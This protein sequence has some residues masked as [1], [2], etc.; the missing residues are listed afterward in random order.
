[1]T[2]YIA[3]NLAMAMQYSN[4][5]GMSPSNVYSSGQLALANGGLASLPRHRYQDGSIGGGTIQGTPMSG[6]RTGYFKPWKSIKKAAKKIAKPFVKT[7]KKIVPKELAGIMQVAAPFIAPS[8]PWLA[9]GLSAAGQ[10]RQRGRIS[11]LQTLLSTAPGWT[12]EGVM[13]FANRIPG[14]GRFADWVGKSDL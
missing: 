10:A 13:K 9:A 1:M 4:Q 12:N 3:P 2:Q 11:P 14:G 5:Q 6:G 8:N 7:A